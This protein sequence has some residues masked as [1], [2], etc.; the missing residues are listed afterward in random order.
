MAGEDLER[1]A[2]PRASRGH[3]QKKI[4]LPFGNYLIQNSI[5]IIKLPISNFILKFNNFNRIITDREY[6]NTLYTQKHW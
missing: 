4:L 6:E 3:A 5:A 1:I 2:R